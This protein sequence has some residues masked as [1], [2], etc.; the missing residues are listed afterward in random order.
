[1]F[2]PN[3]FG[4]SFSVASFNM[5]QQDQARSGY[6]RLFYYN[7]QEQ[8]LAKDKERE[9]KQREEAA[10]GTVEVEKTEPVAK[11]EPKPKRRVGKPVSRVESVTEIQPI[12][13]RPV[14]N[15]PQP[16][17]DLITPLL[18]VISNQL[19]EDYLSSEPLVIAML[20]RKADNDEDEEDS[21]HLLMIAA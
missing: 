18:R 20:K 1:M 11:P 9:Q 19:Y 7:M 21:I 14:Y 15:N 17:V 16:T 5:A 3:S 12:H 10:Q 8:S 2:Q 4:V 6:W 13:P